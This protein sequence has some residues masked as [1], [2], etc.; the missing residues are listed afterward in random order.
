[1]PK[2]LTK[3]SVRPRDLGNDTMFVRSDKRGVLLSAGTHFALDLTS[4]A[5]RRVART[6]ATRILQLCDYWEN[7]QILAGKEPHPDA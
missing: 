4:K 1:M 2:N 7:R 6:F 5:Q 3:P